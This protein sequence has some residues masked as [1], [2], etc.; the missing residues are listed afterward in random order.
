[1]GYSPW[2]RKELDMAKVTEHA[3]FNLMLIFGYWQPPACLH[4]IIRHYS[5][6]VPQS[7]ARL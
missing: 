5:A 3:H 2:G 1:M 6:S 4:A 7:H